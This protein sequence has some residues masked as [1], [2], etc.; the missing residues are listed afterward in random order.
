MVNGIRSSEPRGLSKV[1][2]LKV[3]VGSWV[4]Q[5]TPEERRGEIEK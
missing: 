1:G 3:C 4:Q 5:K 2:G